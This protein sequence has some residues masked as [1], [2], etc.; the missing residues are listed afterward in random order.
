MSDSN[1]ASPE[2]NNGAGPRS[3][4]E[5]GTVVSACQQGVGCIL[6]VLA[7]SG[8]YNLKT[9]IAEIEQRTISMATRSWELVITLLIND[10]CR[11]S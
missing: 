10:L 1:K 6:H 8:M 2:G 3:A 4:R 7:P 5:D 9:E 11:S